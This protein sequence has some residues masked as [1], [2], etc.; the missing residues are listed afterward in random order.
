MRAPDPCLGLAILTTPQLRF[1]LQEI[2]KLILALRRA[3]N[4]DPGDIEDLKWL[5]DRQRYIVALLTLRRAQIGKKIISLE[6][7]RD[8]GISAQTVTRAA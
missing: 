7:W 5:R 6:L 2:H 4:I 1:D 8:G 3:P